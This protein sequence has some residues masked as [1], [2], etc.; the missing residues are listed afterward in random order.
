MNIY[1][2]EAS[3]CLVYHCIQLLRLFGLVFQC[4]LILQTNNIQ[5]SNVKP[6]YFV[7]L[8]KYNHLYDWNSFL[9][10]IIILFG[11]YE[12]LCLLFHCLLSFRDKK[13]CE[14]YN[15]YTHSNIA[16]I[17]NQK[18]TTVWSLIITLFI[19][20][21]FTITSFIITYSLCICLICFI[22][23]FWLLRQKIQY[24]CYT[25]GNIFCFSNQI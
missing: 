12:C 15:F 19:M 25:N 18:W 10:S 16:F 8:I 22:I 7:F 13:S 4:L 3:P 9:T 21:L 23:V 14:S 17:S 24:H 11:L 2:I 20:T 1:I 5:N 6:H